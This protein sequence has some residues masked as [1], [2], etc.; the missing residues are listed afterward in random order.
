VSRGLSRNQQAMLNLV[1]AAEFRGLSSTDIQEGLG[2]HRQSISR[3]MHNLVERGLVVDLGLGNGYYGG[4]ARDWVATE[5][6][7]GRDAWL[8]QDTA[9]FMKRFADGLAER[10]RERQSRQLGTESQS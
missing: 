3:A 2:L 9:A 4:R 7:D 8:K 10:A 6:A 5:F 1:R